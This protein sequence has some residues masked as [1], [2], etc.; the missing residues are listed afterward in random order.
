MRPV[1]FNPAVQAY[2]GIHAKQATPRIQSGLRHDNDVTFGSNGRTRLILTTL[3]LGALGA[4]GVYNIRQ[5]QNA[6]APVVNVV[7][8]P[9]DVAKPPQ[10][11]VTAVVT[12]TGQAEPVAS[13]LYNAER[14]TLDVLAGDGKTNGQWDPKKYM[15]EVNAQGMVFPILGM[16][17]R[18]G[19]LAMS[20][21]P[22]YLLD[23]HDFFRAIGAEKKTPDQPHTMVSL[24]LGEVDNA[25]T[26]HRITGIRVT[27]IQAGPHK[28]DTQVDGI[29]TE[30]VGTIKRTDGRPL[31]HAYKAA[32]AYAALVVE[33]NYQNPFLRPGKLDDIPNVERLTLGK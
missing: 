29:R 10:P 20:S 23:P 24:R 8:P 27:P 13:I 3:F 2:T 19:T 25:G 22:V 26:I 5:R 7:N 9:E 12:K 31:D 11:V 16:D 15:G 32:A 14:D 4:L 6:P 17:E 30:N 18:T 33:P 1:Q 21:N 28:G